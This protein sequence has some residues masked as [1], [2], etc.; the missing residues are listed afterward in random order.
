[1]FV[2]V[3]IYTH[4]HKHTHTHTQDYLH[5]YTHTH[6]HTRAR[7]H[8]HKHTHLHVHDVALLR[9][10]ALFHVLALRKHQ[11]ARFH[12]MPLIITNR[13][14]VKLVSLIPGPSFKPKLLLEIPQDLPDEAATVEEDGRFIKSASLFAALALR[15]A[16]W[17]KFSKVSA[18]VYLQYEARYRGLLRIE[19]LEAVVFLVVGHAVVRLA[20]LYEEFP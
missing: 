6:T 12:E 7:V 19:A 16:A 9:L 14:S 20:S 13:K 18:L 5:T 10:H 15:L 3:S 2:C 11:I 8:T 4:T 1:V 17:H